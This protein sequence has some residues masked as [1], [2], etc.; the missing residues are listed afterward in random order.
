MERL[1][2]KVMARER[3]PTEQKILTGNLEYRLVDKCLLNRLCFMK[4]ITSVLYSENNYDNND[5]DVAE[6]ISLKVFP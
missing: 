3:N 2:R 5:Y 4:S 1:S 6:F